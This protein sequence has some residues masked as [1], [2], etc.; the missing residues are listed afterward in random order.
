[1]EGALIRMAA[2]GSV[3][4]IEEILA[5]LGSTPA[6]PPTSQKPR[7]AGP[8]RPA[9][10]GR[11]GGRVTSATP[12]PPPARPSPV[13]AGLEDV[14][15]AIVTAVTQARPML[16]AILERSAAMVVDGGTL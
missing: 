11:P 16:G 14:R 12:V 9:G 2:L 7:D 13:A 8:G 4:P 15:D 3:R 1:F 5:S 6:I 10:L